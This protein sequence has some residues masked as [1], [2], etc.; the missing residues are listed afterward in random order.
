M[1]LLGSIAG[2][3]AGGLMGSH[4]ARQNASLNKD[5]WKYQQSNAHQ[6]EV[7]D[8]TKAGLNPILSATGGQLAGMPSVSGS[9]YGVG[10]NITSA[11]NTA[12]VT[13]ANKENK[14]L[15]VEIEKARLENDRQRLENENAITAS[16]I[17][18][19]A[20]D[21]EGIRASTAKV[22]AEE[23]EVYQ[24]IENSIKDVQSLVELRRKQGHLTEAQASAAY[25]SVEVMAGQIALDIERKT[26]QQLSNEQVIRALQDPD[27]EIHREYRKSS[28][29]T[30]LGYV[31]DAIKD[32]TPFRIG[33]GFRK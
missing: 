29:G 12:A 27:S 8:L 5:L 30:I 11:L 1:S 28:F 21:I 17:S 3:V 31:G 25:K 6:L 4:S 23:K 10:Q 15:D 7:Q 32:L 19:N 2:A 16:T 33:F 22:A 26:G 9:D 13:R 18:K 20:A 24:R 14:L